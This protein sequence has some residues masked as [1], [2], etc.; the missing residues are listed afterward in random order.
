[1]PF[2]FNNSYYLYMFFE[3]NI[4]PHFYLKIANK[5]ETKLQELLIICCKN[6]YHVEKLQ[7]Q[8]DYSALS[9]KVMYLIIKYG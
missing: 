3:K 4:D 6:L 8:T 9:L 1:M 5:L 2:E 7:Q